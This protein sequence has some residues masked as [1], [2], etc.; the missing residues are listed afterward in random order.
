MATSKT[1]I[2]NLAI[3]HLGIGKEI[4]NLDTEKSEEAQACRRF[5]ELARKKVLRDFNWP[6]ATKRVVLSLIEDN[7][8]DEYGYSYRYPSDC[9]NIHKIFSGTRNDT[10]QSRVHFSIGKDSSARVI[11]TDEENAEVQYTEDLN[12]PLF[13]PP[14][15]E[16]AFSY[17]LASLVASRL[18]KGDPFGLRSSALEAYAAAISDTKAG[19][20]NEEQAEEN[21]VSEFE[22]NRE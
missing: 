8:N 4:A 6:F 9:I 20:L 16:L 11:F 1:V 18:T 10:R 2:C 21:P 5:Y 22:R 12:N 17:F 13:F 7:P 15:F 19:S 14:D 3:S